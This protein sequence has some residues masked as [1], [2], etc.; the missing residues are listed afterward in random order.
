[1]EAPLG[2]EIDP[3]RPTPSRLYKYRPLIDATSRERLERILVYSRLYF[4]SRLDFNDPFD[5]LVPSF[6]NVNRK[7]VLKLLERRFKKMRIPGDANAAAR[8][9]DLEIWRKD[10]QSDVD[11]AGI[12]SLTE[13][14]DNLLMWAHYAS[15]HSGVC[16]EFAVSIYEDFFGRAQPVVYSEKRPMFNPR[17]TEN[18]WV[19]TALLRKSAD[20]SYEREWRIID[21]QVGKGPKPFR[22]ELLTGV[23]FGCRISEEDRRQVRNWLSQSYRKVSFYNGQLNERE[24]KI[25]VVPD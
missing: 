12:L 15:S 9:I 11:Q 1:V 13:R 24:W 8:S 19:D 21:H 16:L 17:G 7:E 6:V 3:K 25:D 2:P 23:I 18:E 14:R 20:W 4:P 10:L 5:C 22:P